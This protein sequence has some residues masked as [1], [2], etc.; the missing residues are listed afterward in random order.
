LGEIWAD[1]IR[2]E[3]YQNLH[4]PKTLIS[5]SYAKVSFILR[6]YSWDDRHNLEHRK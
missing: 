4:P 3:Q 6:Q 2:F 5:Y 1:L